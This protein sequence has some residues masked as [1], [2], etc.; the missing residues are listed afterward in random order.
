MFTRTNCYQ[1]VAKSLEKETFRNI[2]GSISYFR[3]DYGLEGSDT[4]EVGS[5]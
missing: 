4:Y 3:E 2:I 1:A 5:Y